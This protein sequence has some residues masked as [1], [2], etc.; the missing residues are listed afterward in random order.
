M[1]GCPRPTLGNGKICY[2]QIPAVDPAQSAKFYATVFGWNIRKRDDG[3]I[4]F[5]DGVGEVSGTWVTGQKPAAEP[6]LL[7]YI[8]VENMAATIDLVN[9]HGGKI[10]QPPDKSAQDVIALFSDPAANVFGLYEQSLDV[11]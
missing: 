11:K 5:D 8:M 2:I 1:K 9:A 10:L 6:N 3:S 7:I 4:A